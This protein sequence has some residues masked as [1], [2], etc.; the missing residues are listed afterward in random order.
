MNN[1][2]VNVN[3]EF[4]DLTKYSHSNFIYHLT[5]EIKNVAYMKLGSIEFP[6]SIYNFSENKKN[7]SFK[8]NDG[9]NEDT[10]IIEEG[11]YTSDTILVKIQ[12]LLD[13]INSS[14]SKDYEIQLN[15]NTGKIFFTCSNNFTLDF[16]NNDVGYGSLGTSLGFLNENYTGKTITADKVI[17][18]NT[19]MYYFLKINNM[20]SI[21]DNYVNNAFAKIIQTSGSFDFNFEG[22]GDFTSK[23]IVFR[24]PINLNKLEVQVVDFKNR[25]VD[26]NGINLS[27]SLEVGYIYDKKLYEEINNNGLPNG[28]NRLKYYY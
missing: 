7:I 28:D 14:R 3:S 4:V 19:S 22:K 20:G 27:F 17:S 15:I 18:L 13:D 25:I 21:K 9:S 1:I 10:I 2:I 26:F 12:D 6:T 5:D 23:D 8:I 16:S 11:N 24:S